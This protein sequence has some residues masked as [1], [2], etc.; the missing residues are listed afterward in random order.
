MGVPFF[1]TLYIYLQTEHTSVGLNLHHFLFEDIQGPDLEDECVVFRA[2][3]K[4]KRMNPLNSQACRFKDLLF[5]CRPTIY[6]R[7]Y[8][9]IVNVCVCVCFCV[10]VI[11]HGLSLNFKKRSLKA[12]DLLFLC[13]SLQEN[14]KSTGLQIL[15]ICSLPVTLLKKC[16]YYVL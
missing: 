14:S 10:C 9:F 13:P 8:V 5:V 2:I 7:M 4:A 1:P 16:M 6:L 12:T 11:T 3:L 15:K